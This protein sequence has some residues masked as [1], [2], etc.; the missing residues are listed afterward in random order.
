[1][2][3]DV[4]PLPEE[5]HLCGIF[6]TPLDMLGTPSHDAT[7]G[8]KNTYAQAMLCTSHKPLNTKMTIMPHNISNNLWSEI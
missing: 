7:E 8:K 5:C 1:M 2:A 4:L 6:H 3:A